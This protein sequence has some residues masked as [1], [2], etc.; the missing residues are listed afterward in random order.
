MVIDTSALLAVL[1][2]EAAA[3]R[4][5]RAVE[6]A[7]LRL[8]SAAN[9]LE[10]SIVID[11]CKGEAG[12]RELDLLL[13]RSG[14]EIVAVD[15]DQV[16]IARVAWRRFGKGR[17]AAALNYGDCFAYALAKSRRLSLLFIGTDFSQTDIPP[18]LA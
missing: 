1:L 17:H 10:A 9:L 11:S 8:L 3:P 6:A 13:Y 12:G 2:D 18:A 16:E 14:I 15:H 5:A 7:P 4:V